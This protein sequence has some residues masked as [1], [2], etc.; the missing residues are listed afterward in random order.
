[1]VERGDLA[2][3]RS[4]LSPVS[5][6]P[7]AAGDD[8]CAQSEPVEALY[9]TCLDKGVKGSGA[10]AVSEA[11]EQTGFPGPLTDPGAGILHDCLLTSEGFLPDDWI[12]IWQPGIS[13]SVNEP[14]P[15]VLQDDAPLL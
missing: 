9:E 6:E 4:C 10:V 12:A 1:M 7:G 5:G 13:V 11:G 14:V 15:S 2:G 8:V 3:W